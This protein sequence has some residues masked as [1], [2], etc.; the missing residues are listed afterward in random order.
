M[1]HG[2]AF[3]GKPSM[4]RISPHH[5]FPAERDGA[6]DTIALWV[7]NCGRDEIVRWPKAG[8]CS[9]MGYRESASLRRG[10]AQRPG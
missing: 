2:D 6:P 1:R 4:I 3:F 10:T 8:R 9:R 7:D 5:R